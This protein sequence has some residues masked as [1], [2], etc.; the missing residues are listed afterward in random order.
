[1]TIYGLGGC[2]K[3]ALA[4]EFAYRALERHARLVFWVPAI[5]QESFEL[6]YHEIGVRL[7]IPGLSDDNADVKELVQQALNSEAV[8]DWLLIVDNADDYGVLSD[9]LHNGLKAS[10]LEDFL[11]RSDRG[12]ILFTTRSRKVAGHLAQ[13]SVLRLS[14][15]SK[16][17]ARQLLTQQTTEQTLRSSDTTIDELLETLTCLPLAIVQAA[18]FMNN[19]DV[20][21][22]DYLTLFQDAD[23]QAELCH[24]SFVDSSRYAEVDNTIAKTWHV[25]F[26][27]MR[28]QDPLAAEYL[29]FMACID[30]VNILRSLLPPGRSKVQHAKALVTLTG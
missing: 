25:S 14:D 12:A 10:R 15:I 22:S 19:N 9:K 2:G 18:A 1:M 24:E 17:E 21:A 29:S 26:D 27:Q 11:P 6:A 3:S 20:S 13:S 23:T 30:R 16:E 4:I 7:H 28:K 5:S 8:D